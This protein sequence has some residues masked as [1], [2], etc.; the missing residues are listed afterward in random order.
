M[1][2]AEFLESFRGKTEQDLTIS[3]YKKLDGCMQYRY[4]WF[5]AG[6]PTVPAHAALEYAKK[7][8]A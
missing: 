8:Q 3:D 6:N 4:F 2:T 5:R 1:V 7:G